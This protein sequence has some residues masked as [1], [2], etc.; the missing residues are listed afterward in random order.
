MG[1]GGEIPTAAAPSRKAF[2]DV[3]PTKQLQQ[4]QRPAWEAL[5]TEELRKKA[6]QFGHDATADRAALL[7]ELVREGTYIYMH[8]HAATPD[9]GVQ[10]PRS[11]DP[12]IPTHPPTHPPPWLAQAP[13]GDTLLLKGVPAT[14]PLAPPPFTLADIKAAVPRHC[15]E[16]SLSTSLV[17]LVIDLVQVA[18]LGYLATLIGHPDVPPMT[19][20]LLWP[21][22]WYAQG[23]VLTGV[24]VIAHEC[25]HQAFSPYEAVNNFVG[26]RAFFPLSLCVCVCL[27]LC[28]SVSVGR[29]AV[30]VFS[31][32]VLTQCTTQTPHP[33]EPTPTHTPHTHTHTP[34]PNP[35]VPA[36]WVLHSAL[37]VPYHSWRIS[38]GKHHNNTG[39]CE[40]DEVF[41]PPVKEDLVDEILLHS[42]LFNLFQVRA[43]LAFLCGAG[44]GG[45]VGAGVVCMH[46]PLPGRESLWV[47][48]AG[49]PCAH[50]SVHITHPPPC[51]CPPCPG[52]SC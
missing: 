26:A 8:I 50:T 41:A 35:T 6:Q 18:I 49:L 39:S 29:C 5:P 10:P 38:H 13:Y 46:Q 45:G 47:A 32:P 51:P 28:V 42:P 25:G 34:H 2:A 3:A 9:A 7:R 16:R 14:L 23:A 33:H 27:S 43:G 15:F 4:Q 24:W 30:R 19:R 22:Y 31:C 40:N 37:L 12:D 21:L 48:R 44:V 36:G 17:H 11:I 52:R 1:R 20:Y